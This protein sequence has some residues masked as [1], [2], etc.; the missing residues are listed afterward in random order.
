MVRRGDGP[1]H[2]RA[3]DDGSTKGVPRVRP[4]APGK[5]R[6]ADVQQRHGG[7]LREK[8]RG[9]KVEGTVQSHDGVPGM[10][11]SRANQNLSQVHSGEEERPGRRPQQDGS[12]ESPPA[13]YWE[14]LAEKRREA[15]EETLSENEKLAE[16]NK[17][18]KE[19]VAQLKEENKLL[20]EMVKEAKELAELVEGI[21]SENGEES[22]SDE[23]SCAE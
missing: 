1:A 19:E 18:L 5:H 22:A 13:E 16:E 3:R 9:T 2:K 7:G 12:S 11:Q 15:L 10:G 14:E 20:D 6:G 8:A 17:C 23:R 21:T 4:T